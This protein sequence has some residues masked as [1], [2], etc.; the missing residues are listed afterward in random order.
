MSRGNTHALATILLAGANGLVVHQ[1]GYP[2]THTAAL[3][4]G[5]LAGLLLT[6]DLD[7][8]EGCFANDIVRRTA[9]RKA[10]RLWSLFWLP[11]SRLIR[12]RSHL[13][14]LPLLGTALRLAYLL[15]LP[16]FMLWLAGNP[17]GLQVIPAWG[18][19]AAGGLALADTLHY[20][21]DNF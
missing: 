16:L 18:W 15:A 10:E 1:L 4:G 7:I 17:P 8:D 9:G 5:T 12:H 6:P 21:M 13:S 2:V 14:H 19:W 11:Y 3:T 20:V